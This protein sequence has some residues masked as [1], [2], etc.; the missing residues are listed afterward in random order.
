M[1]I[2]LLMSSVL[3]DIALVVPQLGIISK[4]LPCRLFLDAC[5]G[6]WMGSV[7]LLT[8][9]LVCILLSMGLDQL[10]NPQKA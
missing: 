2:S 3:V 10:H 7:I 9:S 4:L 5:R 8:G 6:D 1:V